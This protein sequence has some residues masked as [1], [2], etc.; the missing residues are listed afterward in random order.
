MVN[1][2]INYK[3]IDQIVKNIK[4]KVTVKIKVL[5]EDTIS[6]NLSADSNIKTLKFILKQLFKK[7]THFNLYAYNNL[8]K[9]ILDD[10]ILINDIQYYDSIYIQKC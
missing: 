4:K 10:D 3:Y 6:I 8:N 2:N 7:Y 9:V 5:G 1:C